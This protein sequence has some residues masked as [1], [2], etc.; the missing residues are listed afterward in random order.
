MSFHSIPVNEKTAS[1]AVN[2]L[3]YCARDVFG[4]RG[5]KADLLNR[6]ADKLD[7]ASTAGE[8]VLHLNQ[9]DEDDV[10][11]ALRHVAKQIYNSDEWQRQA[12]RRLASQIEEAKRN[13][14]PSPGLGRP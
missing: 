10:G 6:T 13:H 2:A 1:T 12:L 9:G 11:E 14:A 7:A 3:R 8:N 5:A 4:D